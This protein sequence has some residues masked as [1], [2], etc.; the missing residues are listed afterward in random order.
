MKYLV[1]LGDGMAGL[2]LE[3]LDGKTVLQYA[4]TPNLDY[5]ASRGKLGLARTVPPGMPPGSDVANLSV[6][7]YDLRKYYTGRAPWKPRRWGFR[8]RRTMWPTGAI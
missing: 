5:M 6:L 2:P 7:G 8:S 1:L 3:E 4:K